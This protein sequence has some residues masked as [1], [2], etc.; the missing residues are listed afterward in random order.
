VV[1]FHLLVVEVRHVSETILFNG[2]L[3]ILRLS[4]VEVSF[5]PFLRNR[6]KSMAVNPRKLIGLFLDLLPAEVFDLVRRNSDKHFI[7]EHGVYRH[8]VGV[9][10]FSQIRRLQ[11]NRRGVRKRFDREILESS[12]KLVTSIY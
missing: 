8:S 9:E 11:R 1:V 4:Q 10:V 2:E 12:Q 5:K 7:S 3:F 6:S